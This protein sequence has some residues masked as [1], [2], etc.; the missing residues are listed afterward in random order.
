MLIESS[1][2]HMRNYNGRDLKTAILM[3]KDADKWYFDPMNELHINLFNWVWPKI[4]QKV[5]NEFKDYWNFHRPHHLEGKLLPTAHF[6]NKIFNFPENYGLKHCGVKVDVEVVEYLRQTLGKSREECLRWVPDEF[7]LQAQ[8]AYE[9]L[10]EPELKITSG[11][12]IFCSML[13]ILKEQ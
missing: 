3:T 8:A 7:E 5:V 9:Q 10:G 12:T 6:P 13:A 1:W 4:A 2:N 11:W